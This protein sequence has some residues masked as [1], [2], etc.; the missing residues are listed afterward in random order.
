[1][2]AEI[3]VLDLCNWPDFSGPV[4]T[5]LE[6]HSNAV[7]PHPAAPNGLMPSSIKAFFNS[8]PIEPEEGVYFS[9]AELPKRF[10]YKPLKEEEIENVLTGGAILTY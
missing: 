9:R 5:H 6:N 3:E 7:K 1:M 4:L 10:Q 8:S 2:K